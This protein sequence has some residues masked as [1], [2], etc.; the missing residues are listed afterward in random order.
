MAF[1]LFP[2]LQRPT[3]LFYPLILEKHKPKQG[4]ACFFFF[5]Q[6]PDSFSSLF[7]RQR[8]PSR[9]WKA[10][11]LGARRE[12]SQL[13]P[14][15]GGKEG[16]SAGLRTTELARGDGPPCLPVLLAQL[17]SICPAPRSGATLGFLPISW[18]LAKGAKR[19]ADVSCIP[20]PAGTV[21]GLYSP[22][23]GSQERHP[24]FIGLPTSDILHSYS[25]YSLCP[26]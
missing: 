20:K 14:P 18:A 15:K 8:P 25:F 26:P 2:P 1:S 12:R 13:P 9:T 11:P 22:C 23:L 21:V 6:F 5:F 17:L 3:K 16:G 10:E 24:D 7:P 19:G 4:E